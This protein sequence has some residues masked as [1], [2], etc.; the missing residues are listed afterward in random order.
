MTKRT[1]LAAAVGVAATAAIAA[2]TLGAAPAHA[3]GT[4]LGADA[5]NA[6][7]GE[8]IVKLKDVVTTATGEGVLASYETDV[9]ARFPAFNGFLLEMSADEARAL[10]ADPSVDYVEQ[11]GTVSIA[12]TQSNPPSWGLDRIDQ[13]SLPLD[14]SYTYP[15]S[16]GSGVTAYIIDTGADLDHPDFGGRMTSG[17]DTVDNDDDAE[18]CQG[19]GTHV[20]GTVGGT[21]YGVAKSV[22]MVAVRVLDCNGSGTYDGVIAGVEWVTANAQQ[23]AVA[24]MSLG[25]GFSQAV[26]DA[27]A[28]SI[29]SGVTYALAAGNDYGSDACGG[30]PGSTP[31][32]LTVGSTN[33]SDA[34]SSFSNIGSCVD[35]FA[36]GE[37]I[38][39]AWLNGGEST[40]SGTSMASPHVAGA[41]ALHLG[42]NPSATPAEVG[43]ALV[44]NAVDG[45]VGNPGS[46]SPNK[47]LNIGYLNG[48]GGPGEP[49]PG[50]C[51]ATSDSATA[52]ADRSTVESVLA[53][54]CE[55]AGAAEV[56][57]DITHTYR[58][59]LS[60]TLVSP[61]GT[62]FRLKAASVSDSAD[63]VKATFPVDL[64][65]ETATGDW[66]LVVRDHYRGDTGTLNSWSL[67]M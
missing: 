25:G 30:S 40:I 6:I 28:A 11:N 64:S 37:G 24:N 55:S 43:T 17:A 34:R 33:S 32:A 7:D 20:A 47:L 53:L 12:G 26:N 5:P 21:E 63:D 62:K 3:E 54:S 13:D 27:V 31:E 59:D 18:D 14:D 15:D 45:A 51:E 52:I 2:V 36:P 38:T 56:T 39:S 61:D 58:G 57:V 23:P 22:D 10:A 9:A 67:T 42:E 60:I 66:T 49:G 46:G 8:Y 44:D 16:A 4:V 1:R 19:H 29:A 41:A 48:G 50:D 35:V 65:G